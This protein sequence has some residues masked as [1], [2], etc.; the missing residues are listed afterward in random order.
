MGLITYKQDFYLQPTLKVAEALVGAVLVREIGNMR[1]KGIVVE[2]EA[3]IGT[4][5]S[6]CHAS[7]G[8]TARTRVMFGEAGRA[9]V[10]FVYGMHYMFNVVTEAAGHP[11]AVLIR[12]VQ[13]LNHFDI[14]KQK[15]KTENEKNLANGP[16]KLCQAYE[17]S[18]ELNAWN[19]CLGKKLWLQEAGNRTRLQ[20]N[21][22][23]RIGIDYA[24]EKDRLA[25][26][27]FT[28]KDSSFL[29]K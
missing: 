26:W 25:P 13:P 22:S 7:R 4:G 27:R 18:K 3:Y 23:P 12:A 15:R 24:E 6:A 29:S 17:I 28:L 5:D 16:A 10:Y 21:A 2:T 14:L 1:F 19:L 8:R 20:V 11:S 9:Y